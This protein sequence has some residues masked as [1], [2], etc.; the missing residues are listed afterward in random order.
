MKRVQNWELKLHSFIER[1]KNTP[2]TWG[3]SDCASFAVDAV[4]EIIENPH[5]FNPMQSFKG[6]YRSPRG[7]YRLL[8]KYSGGGLLDTCR[9]ILDLEGFSLKSAKFA[10]RGDFALVEVDTVIGGIREVLGVVVDGKV[11]TQGK[12]GLVFV[13]L[14]KARA[15]WAI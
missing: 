11:V 14:D 8:K 12:D 13:G 3:K 2:M 15:V 9:I 6:R 1:R 7:A 4:K 5:S 10:Q